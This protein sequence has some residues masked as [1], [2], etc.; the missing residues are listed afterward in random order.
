[1]CVYCV[2]ISE[3][4]QSGRGTGHAAPS[5]QKRVALNSREELEKP[6]SSSNPPLP[7]VMAELGFGKVGAPLCVFVCVFFMYVHGTLE[8]WMNTHPSFRNLRTQRVA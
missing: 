1:M 3:A 2:P 4:E 5:D 6:K 7:T 8:S